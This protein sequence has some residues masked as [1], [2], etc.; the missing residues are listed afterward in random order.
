[1]RAPQLVIVETDGW[2]AR[3][4]AEFTAESAWLVRAARADAAAALVRDRRPSV[5]VVQLDPGDDAATAAALALVS[6]V[7]A[8]LPDVPVVVVS[9]VKFNDADRVAWTAALFDLGARYALFPPLTRPVF[10][11]VVSGLMAA[12]GRRAGTAAPPAP[13]PGEPARL[14]PRRK[15]PEPEEEVIDL[16]DEED[17]NE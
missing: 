10:E 14:K 4:L 11:D 5:L 12:A 16:A 7:S 9:D 6:D 13:Q 17:V 3:M 1:M 15:K 2:I 8:R